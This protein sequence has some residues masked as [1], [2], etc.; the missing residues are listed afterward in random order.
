M[1]E[2]PSQALVATSTEEPIRRAIGFWAEATTRSETFDRSFKLQDKVQAVAKFFAFAGKHPDEITPEDVQRWR[3]QLESRGQKPATVYAR[4]SRVS[5]FYRWL[6]TDPLLGEHIRSNPAVQARP[7][8]PQPYQSES[9]KALT[10]DEMNRL[11]EAVQTRADVGSVIAKRDYA[12]LLFFFLTG[13]RRNEVISLRGRD[14]EYKEERLVIKYRRKGGKF[15]GR[16]VDDS[17]VYQALVDY[18]NTSQRVNVIGSDRPLWT[19]HDR[20]G[21]PGAPLSSRSFA[22]N[23]KVYAQEAGIEKIHIHQTRHTY[24][25]IVAEETGSFSETQ[26]ALDHENVSTTRVYVQ[27]ITIKSDKYGNKVARRIRSRNTSA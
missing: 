3:Q 25:R 12:I 26:E 19:R 20:A 7:R 14:L 18:L 24:A 17:S 27:R 4:V 8:Y 15:V 13:L 10:D 6:M 23:L 9:V 22:E 1:T 11:L 2:N 5:S 21:K 16:E